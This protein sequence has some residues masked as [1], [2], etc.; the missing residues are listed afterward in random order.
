MEWNH[1][2]RMNEWT[3]KRTDEQAEWFWVFLLVFLLFFFIAICSFPISLSL[4]VCARVMVWQLKYTLKWNRKCVCVFAWM[5]EQANED[6]PT[7]SEWMREEVGVKAKVAKSRAQSHSPP[8][9]FILHWAI[10]FCRF[11]IVSGFSWMFTRVSLF[12]SPEVCVLE[13]VVDAIALAAAAAS[14]I[15]DLFRIYFNLVCGSFG[16]VHWRIS[17]FGC[18]ASDLDGV[19]AVFCCCWC[20]SFTLGFL[21]G[22]INTCTIVYI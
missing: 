18:V 6:Q 7:T 16:I 2:K 22:Y 15:V 21:N 12:F 5:I 8:N 17:R 4:S 9:I 20:S 19:V 11:V 1:L 3:N 10:F 13:C 14:F